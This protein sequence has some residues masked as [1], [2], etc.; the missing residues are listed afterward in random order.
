MASSLSRPLRRPDFFDPS[1][2]SSLSLRRPV[3]CGSRSRTRRSSSCLSAF[4]HDVGYIGYLT[5]DESP[6]PPASSGSYGSSGYDG[7]DNGGGRV[8]NSSLSYESRRQILMGTGIHREITFSQTLFVFVCLCFFVM[9]VVLVMF[10]WGDGGGAGGG[11]AGG[12]R[13]LL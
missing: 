7:G 2:S 9:Y 10:R 13:R 12:R 8:S 6:S 11:G 3:V 1:S 5:D 4:K